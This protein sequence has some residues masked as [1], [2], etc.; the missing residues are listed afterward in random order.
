M[1]QLTSVISAYTLAGSRTVKTVPFVEHFR[2]TR[3]RGR[4]QRVGHS[5]RLC[6]FIEGRTGNYYCCTNNNRP[7]GGLGGS[8]QAHPSDDRRSDAPHGPQEVAAYS[9]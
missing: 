6:S 3:A 4:I 5:S 8:V 9:A 7:C 2:R 1:M